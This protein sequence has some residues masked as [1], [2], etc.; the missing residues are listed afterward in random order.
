MSTVCQNEEGHR[1]GK[2]RAKADFLDS[3]SLQR[4]YFPLL[5]LDQNYDVSRLAIGYLASVAQPYFGSRL[6]TGGDFQS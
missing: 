1:S 5:N 6:Y 3:T 4:S 2:K